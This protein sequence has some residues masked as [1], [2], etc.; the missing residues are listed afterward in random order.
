MTRAS[1]QRRANP[2]RPD[3]SVW[4]RTFPLT[5]LHDLAFAR[6]T[7]EWD[8][9]TYAARG[10]LS[11]ETDT[12][13]WLVPPH[14]AVWLPA[15]FAHAEELHAPVS[16]R[17]LYL[18]PGIAR[19]LPRTPSVLEVSPLLHALIVRASRHGALDRNNR[20]EAH[21]ID[22]LLDELVDGHE[23]PLRL[24]LPSDPRALRL[25]AG[26]R[27]RP[28]DRRS[29]AALSLAAGA[30]RRTME[31]LFAAETGMTVGEWR[32]RLR[33]LHGL[34]RLAAGEAVG[35]AADGA[36]Y[37]STSAFIAAFRRAFGTTPGRYAGGKTT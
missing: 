37:E 33:L 18:A 35:V 11:V 29:V 10:A 24:P 8:Q 34:R 28:D 16:V 17:S 31:R 9:L 3:G 30:S 1:S 2:R 6:H 7:H 15:G 32:R 4:I 20:T 27:K 26:L 5:A 14:R 22:V 25:A 13:R 23:A 19:A 12:A 36:G 21:L